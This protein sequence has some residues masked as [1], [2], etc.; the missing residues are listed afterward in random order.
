MQGKIAVVT[1]AGSGIGRGIARR[2]AAEG[3]AVVVADVNEAGGRETVGQLTADGATAS[4]V[5]TDVASAA[6]AQA[7]IAHTVDAF[8]T[9]D[10]L[11][12]NAGVVG[13]T[14]FL[15]LTEEE[16][17]RV[18]D[19]DL[20]G[21]FLCAQ[22][23]AR[24]LVAAGQPGAIVN[25]GT[26]E[27]YVVTASGENCQVHYN[28]AKGGVIMLTKAVAFELGRHGIRVNGVCPGT[29]DTRF[30]GNLHE[31]P[32]VMD[33]LMRRSIIKRLGQPADIAGA[34]RFLLSDDAEFITGTMLTVDGGW[35]VQ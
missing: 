26:V 4:F 31:S 29:V 7:M 9:P 11:V 22:A 25:I 14:P 1:G 23:F 27:S 3:A 15:E 13:M 20:K 34:V 33:Y 35:L 21:Q 16:W 8:G 19:I 10:Y 18:I 12:N 2:L 24:A 32:A 5:R 17:D 6:D 28:A 30:A